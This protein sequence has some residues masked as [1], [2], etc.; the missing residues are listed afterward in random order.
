VTAT[1]PAILWKDTGR[2]NGFNGP[3][4][5]RWDYPVQRQLDIRSIDVSL[6]GRAA[7][8]LRQWA[9]EEG[10]E[11]AALKPCGRPPDFVVEQFPPRAAGGLGLGLFTPVWYRRPFRYFEITTIDADHVR[12]S[13]VA[14][15]GSEIHN[16][17]VDLER[18]VDFVWF[19]SEQLDWRDRP[20]RRSAQPPGARGEGWCADHTGAHELRWYSLGTP[21]DLVKDGAIEGRDP[22]ASPAVR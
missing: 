8:G 13:G 18:T 14:R 5:F 9:E 22:P 16:Y 1:E 10:V 4:V 15:V 12:R 11:I 19:T 20:P 17:E 6:R 21:T 2:R 3:A 7:I